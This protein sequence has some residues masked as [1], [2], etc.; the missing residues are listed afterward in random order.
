MSVSSKSSLIAREMLGGHKPAGRSFEDR[1]CK[2]SGCKC[3]GI[4]TNPVVQTLRFGPWRVAM[5]NDLPVR[6]AMCQELPPYPHEIFRGLPAKGSRWIDPSMREEVSS[7]FMTE[8]ERLQERKMIVGYRCPEFCLDDLG[9]AQ[10]GCPCGLH[11][12]TPQRVQPTKVTP[13]V[14]HSGITE[15]V[16]KK[17]FM[18]SLEVNSPPA[19]TL[20]ACEMADNAPAVRPAVNVVPEHDQQRVCWLLLRHVSLD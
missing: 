19:D 8:G 11:P 18:V 1:T 2:P 16:E 7:C 13:V 20:N 15:K 10:A 17:L 3:C 14:Q 12:V 9:S 5:Y 4:D 6:P